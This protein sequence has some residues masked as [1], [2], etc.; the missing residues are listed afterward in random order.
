MSKDCLLGAGVGVSCLSL[1]AYLIIAVIAVPVTVSCQ[2][3]SDI[4]A[5]AVIE[6]SMNEWIVGGM[7]AGI[8]MFAMLSGCAKN[9]SSGDCAMGFVGGLLIL[10]VLFI[11]VWSCIGL[12]IYYGYYA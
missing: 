2:F 4:P 1:L 7:L 11:L 9:N 6:L 8:I 3:N 5:D 10:Y 12:T